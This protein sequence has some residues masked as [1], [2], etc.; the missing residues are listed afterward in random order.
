[1]ADYSIKLICSKC[2]W[3][4]ITEVKD[5]EINYALKMV[6]RNIE[7]PAFIRCPECNKVPKFK[8]EI[9][10]RPERNKKISLEA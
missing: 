3:K 2:G 4:V 10:Y 1:L 8:F 5:I 7:R 6:V 9:E